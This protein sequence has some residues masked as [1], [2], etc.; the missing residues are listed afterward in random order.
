MKKE[1]FF[2]N[3]FTDQVFSGNPAGVAF[4]VNEAFP[5]WTFIG[6][7]RSVMPALTLKLNKLEFLIEKNL[8]A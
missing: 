3:S 8:A 5:V 6:S 2:V 4:I 1:I 7:S